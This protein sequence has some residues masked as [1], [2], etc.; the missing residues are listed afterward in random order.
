[1]KLAPAHTDKFVATRSLA[2]QMCLR[3]R[4]RAA[5][6][7]DQFPLR[8]M[9]KKNSGLWFTSQMDPSFTEKS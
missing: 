3:Q 7:L 8:G 4:L 9:K 1:M 5:A 6:K 2:V